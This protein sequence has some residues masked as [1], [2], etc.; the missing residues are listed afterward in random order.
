MKKSAIRK[1]KM[2]NM[3][4]QTVP[5]GPAALLRPPTPMKTTIKS[6][7]RAMTVRRA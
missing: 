2:P 7:A 1:Y 4:T 6:R 3:R 5:K